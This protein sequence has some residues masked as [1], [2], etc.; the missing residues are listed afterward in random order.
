MTAEGIE[1]DDQL[2]ALREF[3]VQQGQGYLFGYPEEPAVAVER[4]LEAMARASA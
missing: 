4:L 2:A 3:G 1:T